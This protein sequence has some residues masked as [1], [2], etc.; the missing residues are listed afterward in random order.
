MENFLT[1]HDIDGSDDKSQVTKNKKKMKK[2]IKM[3]EKPQIKEN[4]KVMK[5]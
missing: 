3:R 1:Y 2:L 4:H 5:K